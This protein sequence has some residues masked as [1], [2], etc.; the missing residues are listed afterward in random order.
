M[1]DI[2]D[3][4]LNRIAEDEQAQEL[5]IKAARK[6]AEYWDALAALERH[7]GLEFDADVDSLSVAVG[8]RPLYETDPKIEHLKQM[9][10]SGFQNGAVVN[11][12]GI[13]FND[14]STEA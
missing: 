5:L 4:D 1:P 12:T 11:E 7:V 8:S 2:T 9:L 10:K 3:E 13:L 6:K 14:S